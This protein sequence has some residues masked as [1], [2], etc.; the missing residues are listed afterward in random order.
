MD[1]DGELTDLALYAMGL[2]PK[3]NVEKIIRSAFTREQL[4]FEAKHW[5]FEEICALDY[6]VI[7]PVD[8]YVLDEETGKYQDLRETDIGLQY[9][10]DNALKLKVT[11]I[12][13]P[14][15]DA[16]ATMI[17][18]GIGEATFAK[19]RDCFKVESVE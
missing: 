13:R 7:L 4:S 19:I 10:F 16:V 12:I 17:S 5:S 9:L 3:E 15:P 8:C 18:S 1:E 6:R 11:G 14:S 2:L